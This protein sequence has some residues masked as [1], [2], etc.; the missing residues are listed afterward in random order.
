MVPCHAIELSSCKTRQKERKKNCLIIRKGKKLSGDTVEEQMLRQNSFSFFFLPSPL[1]ITSFPPFTF[2]FLIRFG[3]YNRENRKTQ[4]S[5]RLPAK[6][7]ETNEPKGIMGWK[8]MFCFP[9]RIL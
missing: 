8:F 2:F 1:L 3:L 5:S 7:D 6:K 9:L 4:Q